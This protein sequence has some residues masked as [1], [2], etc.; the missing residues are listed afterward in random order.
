[1]R[2][3]FLYTHLNTKWA[4]GQFSESPFPRGLRRATVICGLVLSALGKF[5][6]KW[7]LCEKS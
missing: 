2:T 7:H 6:A 1:M 3:K 4:L 5:F